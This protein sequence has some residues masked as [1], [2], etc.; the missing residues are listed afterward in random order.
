MTQSHGTLQVRLTDGRSLS[1]ELSG[2]TMLIGRGA[3]VDISI[4]DLSVANDH[5][6]LHFQGGRVGLEDLGSPTGTY[7]NATRLEQN[8]IYVL[9]VDSN[10]RMGQVQAKMVFPETRAGREEAGLL[11]ADELAEGEVAEPS[12]PPPESVA[13]TIARLRTQSPSIRPSSRESTG[14]ASQVASS[15]RPTLSGRRVGGPAGAEDFGD[16]LA[17]TLNP[18]RSRRRFAV[19]LY[20]RSR[21]AMMLRLRAADRRNVLSYRFEQDEFALESGEQAQVGLSVR[22]Q[23]AGAGGVE[24]P[25]VVQA[26]V[27]DQVAGAARGVLLPARLPRSV[28]LGALFVIVVLGLGFLGVGAALLCPSVLTNVCGFVPANPLSSLLA[29]P[30]PAAP[31]PTPT[32]PEVAGAGGTATQAAPATLPMEPTGTPTPE[33]PAEEPTSSLSPTPRF[34]GSLLTYKTGSAGQVS[35]VVVPV[36]GEPITILGPVSDVTVLDY[37]PADGGKLALKVVDESVESL[38]IV[39]ADGAPIRTGIHQG[40]QRLKAGLWS[41][42]GSW[43]LVEADIPGITT[44]FIYDGLDGALLSQPPLVPQTVTPTFT[45]SRTPTVTRTPTFTLT[46]TITRT[47]TAT[48]TQAAGG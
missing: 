11:L 5:A 26:Y 14:E 25:F 21:S 45:P 48:A 47:P 7:I 28:L 36:D 19:V 10:I 16:R 20:N 12:G 3:G 22:P 13:D 43:L 39:G 38:W 30:P 40:W 35:L 24:Q 17:L 23:H 27:A 18:E 33:T 2:T 1:F 34:G 9:G 46:P 41:P 15:A 6:R 37:T 29:P 42:D 8:R 4:P 32:A 44:F 31:Q